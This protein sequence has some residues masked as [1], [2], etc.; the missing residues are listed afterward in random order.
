MPC[1]SVV[2]VVKTKRNKRG[3]FDKGTSGNP[4]GRPIGSRNK[5]TL[6]VEQ[7]LETD[8]ADLAAKAID[9]AKAGNIH[10]LRLCME[11][12]VPPC[13]ERAIQFK[14]RPVKSPNDLPVT[15]GDIVTAMAEG[16]VTPGEAQQLAFVLSSQAQSIQT[17]DLAPR[18]KELESHMEELRSYRQELG[19]FIESKAL[20]VPREH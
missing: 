12:L 9:L 13:R 19:R 15:F 3:R 1:R 18:L 2:K 10:A 6:L 11:R 14:M 17:D 16:R 5:A 7:M 20:E 4:S 8:A